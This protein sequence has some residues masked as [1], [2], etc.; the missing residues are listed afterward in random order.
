MGSHQRLSAFLP[1]LLLA[2]GRHGIPLEEARAICEGVL[3]GSPPPPVT[4]LRGYWHGRAITSAMENLRITI[5]EKSETAA[6]NAALCNRLFDFE[7]AYAEHN[8]T[9]LRH[10]PVLEDRGSC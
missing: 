2:L 3:A 4:T 8:G 6:W 1:R 10:I 9:Q 7:D 5:D